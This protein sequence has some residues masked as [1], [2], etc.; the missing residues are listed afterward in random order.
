MKIVAEIFIQSQNVEH[1][2]V[3]QSKNVEGSKV[4]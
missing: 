4:V 3:S 2:Q 1:S